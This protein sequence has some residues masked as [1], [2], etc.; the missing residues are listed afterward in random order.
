MAWTL[1]PDLVKRLSRD[2]PDGGAIAEADRIDSLYWRAMV[3]DP[4]AVVAPEGKIEVVGPNFRATLPL[5][6]ENLRRALDQRPGDIALRVLQASLFFRAGLFDST[7]DHLRTAMSYVDAE[8]KRAKV[9]VYVSKELFQYAIGKA[10]YAAGDR[11]AAR[12]AFAA[13]LTEDLAFY[14]AHAALGSIAWTNWSDLETARREYDQAIELYGRDGFVR[15]DYG[16]VLLQAG[17]HE[18]ALAQLDT[19]IALEPYFAAAH[20]NRAV[21]L[22]RLGRPAAAAAEYR[23]FLRRAPRRLADYTAEARRRLTALDGAG[24]DSV[25]R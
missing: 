25:K 14:P 16:T 2:R 20:F 21:A 11:N 5:T 1:H 17:R 8:A 10:Y 3:R 7:V 12:E 24:A 18:E 13:A 22:D 4:F 19:A 6:V 9:P 15:F 23:E